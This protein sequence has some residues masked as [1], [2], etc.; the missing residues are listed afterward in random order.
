M[1]FLI[2]ENIFPKIISYLRD[3]G[4]DVKSLQE[5]GIFRTTDECEEV[6]VIKMLR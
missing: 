2:D 1:K 4:H 6:A 3:M 5:E